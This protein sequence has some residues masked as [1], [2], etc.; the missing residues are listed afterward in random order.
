MDGTSTERRVERFI[1]E[2]FFYEGPPIDDHVS[3]MDTGLL[4]STGVL[5]LVAFL[6]DQFGIVVAD[7][8]LVP[9]NLDSLSH[10]AAY[11]GRKG[12]RVRA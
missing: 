5:E 9:E 8:E 6:E 7:D 4:D 2:N 11:V 1:R 10:I 12:V 3:L